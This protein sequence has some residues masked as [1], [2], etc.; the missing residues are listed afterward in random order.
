MRPI[1]VRVVETL[2]I[3]RQQELV[4]IGVPFKRGQVLSVETL[5][6][7][8]PDGEILPSDTTVQGVWGDGSVRWC[9]FEF[10]LS[11]SSYSDQL[12]TIIQDRNVVV[13]KA[14][15]VVRQGID[16]YEV[17][18]E[19]SRF[20]FPEQSGFAVLGEEGADQLVNL[21]PF[22]L[23]LPNGNL[24]SFKPN[25]SVIGD[26]CNARFLMHQSGELLATGSRL[27]YESKII[28][29]GSVVEWAFSIHNPQAAKHPG[30]VWDLGDEGSF[31]F[32]S[33]EC[34]FKEV[35]STSMPFLQMNEGEN[36]LTPNARWDL[37]QYSSGGKNWKSSLHIERDGL[38]PFEK[39]G[40]ELNLSDAV[41]R[42]ERAD[43]IMFSKVGA[44][45]YIP[46]F[47]QNFP[48]SVSGGDGVVNLSLFPSRKTLYELQGGEK[49]THLLRFDFNGSQ[50]SC[51]HL[52]K[53]LQLT[54]DPEYI[55]ETQ[56][57][58]RFGAG[59]EKVDE[60]VDL[61][62]SAD[63][64]MKAKR[65]II[66]E[67]GWRNYGDLFADHES[68]YLEKGKYFISHYNNQYD[69]VFGFLKQYLYS[70]NN[71][72][73]QLAD[74]LANHVSDI[75]IY[76]TT[77]D[78][79]EYSGGLF[80]HTDHYVDAMLSSHRTYSR[81]QQ[82]DG[83]T[84]TQGGG[85]GGE[86]CYTHGLLLHYY[87]TGNE[88]SRDAVIEL[89]D[90]VTRFYEGTG[91]FLEL[92]LKLKKYYLPKMR[93]A[94]LFGKVFYNKYPLD[95]GVGNYVVALLDRFLLSNDKAFLRNAEKVIS[96]T[97]HPLENIENRNLE[98]VEF[99][100]F[101][102]IFLQ[103]VIRY[104]EI[105]KQWG[106]VQ[107]SRY[108][109]G[110]RVLIKYAIWMVENERPYLDKPEILDY[111]N[112]TWAAQD[113]R[114]AYILRYAS[115]NCCDDAIGKQMREKADE[116]YD[117]VVS[118]LAVSET[119]HFT[120]IQ[121]ILL[122]NHGVQSARSIEIDRADDFSEEGFDSPYVG[123]VYLIGSFAKELLLSLAGFSFKREL[124]W[125]KY[126]NDKA[127]KF[128]DKLYGAEPGA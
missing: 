99:R 13:P 86:H 15:Q 1:E 20:L 112:D 56:T 44:A 47:W 34:V 98:D 14:T 122:Q 60:L 92:M 96:Y 57:I 67:Y 6:V 46:G 114:K 120:R 75:D 103:A 19:H 63:V 62:L 78:R 110:S 35:S 80:W 21:S 7:L 93:E 16:A 88:R 101:Y 121:A 89:S 87:L 72:W 17:T 42:G 126:R 79:A 33:L 52:R 119:A 127:K 71:D 50:S 68:L 59:S 100:W 43:P 32:Q 82:P 61:S 109:F 106:E 84:T 5:A 12:I 18:T 107:D 54:L 108:Q 90:W 45:L 76:H 10:L 77:D 111:P 74:E 104:L 70:K 36:W 53:K 41:I 73:F 49:K 39:K 118:H 3:C 9:L 8:G 128:Y 55:A 124:R 85:P 2:G 38:V 28:A 37:T 29:A 95:R 65:E 102:T 24:C 66:D 125:L 97:V 26:S 81:N 58:L 48:K 23:L 117:Y 83:I 64:G 40:F 51:L 31:F 30:G 91:T 115:E 27:L 11:A 116:L 22:Q 123:I 113:I 94:G 25:Q 69:P 105:K 4:S